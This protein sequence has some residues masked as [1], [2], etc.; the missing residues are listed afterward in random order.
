MRSFAAFSILAT[1]AFSAFTSAAPIPV[2]DSTLSVRS[3][4]GAR[5]VPAL[6]EVLTTLKEAVTPLCGEL[7]ALH[8]DEISQEIVG[9]IVEKIK[10]EIIKA[11][12]CIKALQGEP[13]SVIFGTTEAYPLEN[14]YKLVA[15]ILCLVVAALFAL[16]KIAKKDLAP[17]LVPVGPLLT[18]LLELLIPLIAGLVIG[19]IPLLGGIF[20]EVSELIKL[21]G[22]GPLVVLLGL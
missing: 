12:E 18:E 19:L 10:A 13:W 14:L 5:S 20:A 6:P 3:V 1:L 7:T 16:L 11:I 9:P 21:L 17:I 15:D 22:L 2:T 8:V 4:A